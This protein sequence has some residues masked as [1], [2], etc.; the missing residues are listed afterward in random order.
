MILLNIDKTT[1][2]ADLSALGSSNQYNR[3]IAS[4]QIAIGK[5]SGDKFVEGD[6][7]TPEGVYFT[8]PHIDPTRLLPKTKYG[9]GAIPLNFPNPLDRFERKT[10]YGIWL[11]GAG[12]DQRMKDKQ[13]TEGCVAF[14]NKDIVYLQEWIQP[15]SSIIVVSQDA[16]KVNLKEDIANVKGLTNSWLNSWKA[17]STDEFINHYHTE[18]E[19]NKRNLAEYKT[20]KGR[21]FS[22]YKQMDVMLFDLFVVT[23]PK[24]A[25]SIFNQNFNGDG[26]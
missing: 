14:L 2:R 24:Y 10:G 19:L 17:R 20:Y 21:L 3:T 23:H 26:F 6:N 12:N 11:H 18:F 9:P 25:V 22:R 16:S 1:L 15:S 8:G 13:V 4:F 7:R 5:E